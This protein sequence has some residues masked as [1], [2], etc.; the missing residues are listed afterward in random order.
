[1]WAFARRAKVRVSWWRV[2]GRER[3][4][5]G[6]SLTAGEMTAPLGRAWTTLDAGTL[7]FLARSLAA[8]ICA[9]VI[10][11][12]RCVCDVCDE[13]QRCQKQRRTS[14]GRKRQ[15]PLLR[16]HVLALCDGTGLASDHGNS[17]QNQ[18]TDLI[19]WRP[20]LSPPRPPLLPRPLDTP[21]PNQ[22]GLAS[23]RHALDGLPGRVA[24]KDR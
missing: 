18:D 24:R 16:C 6:K 7:L 21:T 15:A 22:K 9:N 19:L 11:V 8:P 12:W 10:S 1:M 5:A 13:R 3:G 17:N 2:R 4:V 20:D 14:H 23:I